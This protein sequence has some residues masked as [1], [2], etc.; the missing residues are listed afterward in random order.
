MKEY[1]D[2]KLYIIFKCRPGRLT[3]FISDRDVSC[4]FRGLA[5]TSGVTGAN[6]EA[7]RFS[8]CQVEQGEARR[9]HWHA[10]VHPLPG[11]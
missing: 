9:L 2:N 6:A 7:V 4:G 1:S 5:H 3:Q 8:L 10:G 11:V